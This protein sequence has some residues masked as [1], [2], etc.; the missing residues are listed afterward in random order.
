MKK[1]TKDKKLDLNKLR[2][3]L[4][5]IFSAAVFLH[6]TSQFLKLVF[7][8]LILGQ[9]LNL[10]Y[11]YFFPNIISLSQSAITFTQLIE[12][13]LLPMAASIILNEVCVIGLKKMKSIG[14]KTF[15]LFFQLTITTFILFSIALFIVSFIFEIKLFNDWTLLTAYFKGQFEKRVVIAFFTILLSFSYSGMMLN[16]LRNLFTDEQ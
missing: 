10:I 13:C 12:S 2:N 8:S 11:V 6:I 15:L 9:P 3:A 16:R 4:I 5:G 14:Q 1:T 7:V